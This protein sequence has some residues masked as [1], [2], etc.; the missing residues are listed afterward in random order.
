MKNLRNLSRKELKNVLGAAVRGC[1][2]Q[3]P[4]GGCAPGYIFCSNP[5]CCYPPNKPYACL[6]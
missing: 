2:G 5:L 6:D 1:E 4:G 3:I